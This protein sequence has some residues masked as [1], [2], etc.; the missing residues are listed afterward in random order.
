MEVFVIPPRGKH[1]IYFP[2]QHTIVL[3]N[4]ALV[5]IVNKANHGD[6][7]ALRRLHETIGDTQDKGGFDTP[8]EHTQCGRRPL[9]AFKPTS[10]SL[11]LT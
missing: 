8:E 11:F 2:F 7:S 6:E 5:N 10:V 3:G 1:I 4:A 9:G